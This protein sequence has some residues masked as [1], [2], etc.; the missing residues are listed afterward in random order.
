VVAAILLALFSVLIVG[1][2]AVRS[3]RRQAQAQTQL[4]LLAAAI[5]Q[6]TAAW[7]AWQVEGL[8]VADKGWPDLFPGRLFQQP[9]FTVVAGYTDAPS[10]PF[11]FDL[12]DPDDVVRA[13]TCLA[14][15]LTSPAGRGPFIRDRQVA[16]FE[17][18]LK[19]FPSL[20]TP[21]NYPQPT[22]GPSAHHREIIVDPWGTPLRF[23]WVYRD[24]LPRN[25]APGEH[26]PGFL[27]VDYGPAQGGVA[28]P[29]ILNDLFFQDPGVNRLPKVA[30]G[31]VLESAGPDRKY[32]NA[33][34]ISASSQELAEAADNLALRP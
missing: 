19:L 5:A 9:Q 10:N 15:C 7:P 21:P 1:G 8:A 28:I 11:E 13:N 20:G 22:G 2:G 12:T 30:V 27:P 26:M 16:G 29:G 4:A 31:F 17:P 18:I 23:F 34:K 33:W 32:G 6:Y 3:S 24:R 14:Y 25:P